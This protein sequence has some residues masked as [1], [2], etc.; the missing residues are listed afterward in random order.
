MIRK[1]VL[2][3]L[4]VALLV[5]IWALPIAAFSTADYEITI[6]AGYTAQSTESDLQVWRSSDG[7]S[8]INIGV[9]PNEKGINYARVRRGQLQALQD[10]F[11]EQLEAGFAEL[12]SRGISAEF[13]IEKTEI[14]TVGQYKALYFL[15]YNNMTY[16]GKT[17]ATTQHSYNFSSKNKVYSITFSTTHADGRA[18]AEM[19]AMVESFVIKDELFATSSAGRRVLMGTAIGAVVGGAVGGVMAW[20]NKKK[21]ESTSADE[22][23]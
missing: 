23:V 16:V 4:V 15:V 18:D 14:K 2:S 17:T 1:A 5:G 13:E 11:K 6:S 19:N 20:Q 8:N 3:C 9:A 12:A 7:Y 22:A 10:S 21:K